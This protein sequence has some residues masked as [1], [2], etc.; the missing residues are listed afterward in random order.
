MITQKQISLKLNF[1]TL[2]ELDMEVSLGHNNRNRIINDAI[3]LYIDMADT[4]RRNPS[5]EDMIQFCLRWFPR[6][7]R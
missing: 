2:D 6:V 7:G 5:H 1:A 3:R 4:I